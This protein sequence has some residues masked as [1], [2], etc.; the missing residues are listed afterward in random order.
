MGAL[1]PGAAPR[2][3][4]IAAFSHSTPASRIA[5]GR[6]TPRTGI[7]GLILLAA[8]TLAISLAFLGLLMVF[9]WA[10]ED[11]LMLCQ[12]MLIAAGAA[13]LLR[14]TGAGSPRRRQRPFRPRLTSRRGAAATGQT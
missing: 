10:E 2:S 12:A 14:Q 11:M 7:S 8:K 9:T 4:R 1:A 13:I 5:G 6:P 3:A